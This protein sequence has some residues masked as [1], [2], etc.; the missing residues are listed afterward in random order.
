MEEEVKEKEDC[1]E[2]RQRTK[3]TSEYIPDSQNLG[4]QEPSICS[5]QTNCSSNFSD[6][7]EGMKARKSLNL[8]KIEKIRQ[9]LNLKEGQGSEMFLEF[10]KQ[11]T[12]TKN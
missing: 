11:F 9:I 10:F 7:S 1:I 12:E 2:S 6:T 5:Q 8:E 3:R 4:S